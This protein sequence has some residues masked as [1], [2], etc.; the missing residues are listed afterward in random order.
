MRLEEMR[1]SVGNEIGVSGWH[2]VT[3][4]MI[5]RF[6]DITG[7]AYWIHTDPQRASSESPFGITIAHGFLTTS[8]L[9]KMLHDAV[10]IELP[11]KF[12]VNYGFNKL[13]FPSPVPSGS[14]IRAHIT[15]NAVRDID[16]GV[17]M[18]W[19]VVVEIEGKSKPALAAEWLIRAYD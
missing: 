14:R 10:T 13:R 12:R 17:E 2:T 15:A 8:L 16:G 4:E 7:D 19:G 5:D 9:S 18:V 6:A 3:Q 1:A 11:A